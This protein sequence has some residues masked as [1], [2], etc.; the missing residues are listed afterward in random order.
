MIGAII[1]DVVGSRFEF[2]NT[3]DYEFEFLHKDCSFTDDTILTIAVAET[4]VDC[5]T[6]ATAEDFKEHVLKWCRKYPNPKGAYG[7]MFS[8]WLQTS[9]HEPYQSFGNG[10]LMRLSPI[11][12]A[13]KS[14]AEA[15]R[16]AL[17]CVRITHDHTEALIAAET[18]IT[19]C[20]HL[21][22]KNAPPKT[23]CDYVLLESY[24]TFPEFQRGRFDETCQY[25]LP[26]AFDIFKKS[27][28]FVDAIRKAV[29][30]GGDSDTLAAIVGTLAES[31]YEVPSEVVNRVFTEFL[32]EDMRRVIIKFETKFT[33]YGK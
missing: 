28:N 5:G 22:L 7:A 4:L 9:H 13:A 26:L 33:N 8:Y 19:A 6:T 2:D 27:R 24:D 15:K 21:R 25:C 14:L 23:I 10:A 30:F 20:Y 1:G 18:L 29:A 16:L 11:V 3:T 32:P 17:E 12:Y 31:Y